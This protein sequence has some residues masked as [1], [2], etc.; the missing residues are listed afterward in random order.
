MVLHHSREFGF[1]VGVIKKISKVFRSI[2]DSG[3]IGTKR[4]YFLNLTEIIFHVENTYQ[5]QIF[6]IMRNLL[7]LKN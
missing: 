3:K 2:M 7:L 4:W 6:D 1:I 5:S